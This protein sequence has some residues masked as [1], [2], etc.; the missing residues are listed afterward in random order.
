MSRSWLGK[1]AVFGAALFAMSAL[2]SRALTMQSASRGEAILSTFRN[3]R[4]AWAERQRRAGVDP[5]R[6]DTPAV[7]D[8]VGE[9]VQR[10]RAADAIV[11]RAIAERRWGLD[12]AAGIRPLL[13]K[14][15]PVDRD[16]VLKRFVDAV[17][18]N[19]LH[20]DTRGQPPI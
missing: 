15:P 16:A 19:A 10:R 1:V 9:T 5:N 17:N 11:D 18:A 6:T 13:L 8:S 12:E 20:L 7:A 14:L 3:E 4:I 2:E